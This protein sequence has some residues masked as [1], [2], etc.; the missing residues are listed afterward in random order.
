MKKNLKN[1]LAWSLAIVI[2][3]SACLLIVGADFERN[4]RLVALLSGSGE[5]LRLD[6]AVK[7]SDCRVRGPLPDHDCTPGAV[8]PD[9]TKEKICVH[10]YSKTV[11]DVPASLKKKAHADYGIP[12]PQERGTYEV[13]HLISLS[14]GGNN[15]LANLFP[16]AAEP[17]PGFKEKDLVENYLHEEVCDNR[18][19]LS[20]AQERIAS[21]WVSI[22]MNLSPW[23][24]SDLK[25]RYK[26]WADR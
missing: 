5:P 25:R 10:G 11:R 15:D 13:D 2:F 6:A 17:F 9:V 14:L 3:A 7:S 4:R 21:D 24:I 22:Y 8:F 16:E 26:S 1:I 18:V 19:A 12:Y 23:R 20:I